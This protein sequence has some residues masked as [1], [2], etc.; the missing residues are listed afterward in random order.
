MAITLKKIVRQIR[1]KEKD[2]NEVKYSDYDII[3]AV[4]R[5]IRYINQSFALKNS[6][7]LEKR[8]TYNQD[9]MNEAVTEHNNNLAEGET[10]SDLLDFCL[11]GVD[12]P[13][14]FISL[15]D[16]LRRK[17]NYRLSPVPAVEAVRFGTYKI[18][19]GKIYS[20][21]KDF[22]FL[23]RA[24]IAEVSDIDTDA[25][26]LPGIFLDLISKVSCMIL[27]NNS[28]TD[29]L[30]DEINRVIDGL[31]PARRYSNIKRKMPFYW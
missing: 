18:F 3:D 31:V 10:A 28:S 30:L 26:Q 19:A 17:D 12:L 11:T 24:S 25:V 9:L 4:N 20:S 7:F 6:D 21:S 15:V 22:D 1:I 23:Y 27:L 5:C 29:V 13:A 2:N 14:D 16:V 8:T